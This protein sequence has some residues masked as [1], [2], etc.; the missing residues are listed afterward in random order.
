MFVAIASS[1]R[2][3]IGRC[4]SILATANESLLPNL[5]KYWCCQRPVDSFRSEE[6]QRTENESAST[7]ST[8]LTQN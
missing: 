1:R 7:I 8:S 6:I 2:Q 4:S 3:T 5:D